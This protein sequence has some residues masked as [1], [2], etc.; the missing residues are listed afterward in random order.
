MLLVKVQEADERMHPS[1]LTFALITSQSF[2]TNTKHIYPLCTEY[3]INVM[4]LHVYI[5]VGV[6]TCI[7]NLDSLI[8]E[9]TRKLI[10]VPHVHTSIAYIDTYRHLSTIS[11]VWWVILHNSKQY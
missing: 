5:H 3:H 2:R 4:F 1:L 11:M 9:T 8:Q 10:N 6:Y 7:P